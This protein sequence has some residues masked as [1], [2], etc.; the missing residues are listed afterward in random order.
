ML[1]VEVKW[2]L[3]DISKS[4]ISFKRKVPETE[5]IQVHFAG[6]KEFISSDGIKVMNAERFLSNFI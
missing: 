4:L 2:Q 3:T 6:S 5:A 1:A